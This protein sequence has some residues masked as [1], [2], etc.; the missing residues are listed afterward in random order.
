MRY[1]K[2][3]LKRTR[4]ALETSRPDVNVYR[5]N[6]N[7]HNHGRLQTVFNFMRSGEWLSSPMAYELWGITRGQLRDYVGALRL[8]GYIVE[9][10]TLMYDRPGRKACYTHFTQYRLTTWQPTYTEPV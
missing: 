5:V 7:P 8:R 3:S 2:A 1:G 6:D 9:E 10:Q 4:A